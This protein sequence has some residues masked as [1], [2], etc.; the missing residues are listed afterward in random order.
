M[1]KTY[2]TTTVAAAAIAAALAFSHFGM[3]DQAEAVPSSH[4][5]GNFQ[6]VDQ[7]ASR[8]SCT[9]SGTRKRL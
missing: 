4:T 7:T 2:F 8:G 1:S 9:V 3:S 6:L 5:I